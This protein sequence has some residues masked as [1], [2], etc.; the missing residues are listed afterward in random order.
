MMPIRSTA[1][2]SAFSPGLAKNATTICLYSTNRINAHNTRNTTIRTTKIR[3]DESF[4][5]SISMAER[6]APGG[7]WQESGLGEDGFGPQYGTATAGK[8]S[9]FLLVRSG[10]EL[11]DQLWGLRPPSKHVAA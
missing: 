2:I 8:Q 6:A 5:S 3:G 11:G 9:R 10:T 1:P 4:V 7:I